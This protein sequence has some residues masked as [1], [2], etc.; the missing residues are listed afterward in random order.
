M[1]TQRTTGPS[2]DAP[3][4]VLALPMSLFLSE[5]GIGDMGHRPLFPLGIYTVDTGA[6]CLTS[7]QTPY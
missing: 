6:S 2:E 1:S 4:L 7:A 3:F 5:L